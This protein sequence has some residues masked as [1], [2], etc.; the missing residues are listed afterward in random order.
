MSQRPGGGTRT[1]EGQGRGR[2]HKFLSLKPTD[3]TC[4]A[5]WVGEEATGISCCPLPPM[6]SPRLLQA[7]FP[8]C[9][10]VGG[11]VFLN[12]SQLKERQIRKMKP[13][14]VVCGVGG[15]LGSQLALSQ[16]RPRLQEHVLFHSPAPPTTQPGR[17]ACWPCNY[18]A[19]PR[20]AA[21]IL[22][23]PIAA[24]DE[25]WSSL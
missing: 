8:N 24:R 9:H 3:A 22:W 11:P 14:K 19:S 13:P 6:L 23:L 16:P 4:G 2:G 1:R 25:S 7:G 5:W 15:R 21:P 10:H 20:Q 17:P 18:G 12:K